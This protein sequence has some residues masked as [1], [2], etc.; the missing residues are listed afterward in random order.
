MSHLFSIPSQRLVL[1]STTS[2]VICAQCRRSFTANPVFRSG[3]NR[4]SKIRHEKG[5]ADAKKT[6]QRTAF[7]KNLTLYSKLYGPDPNLNTQLASVITAAKKA[8]MPKANID[9]AIARGQGKS[10]TGAGLESVTLEVMMPPSVAI[11][12]DAETESKSRTL[13]ELKL[14]VKKC[15]GTVTPTTFMFTRLGRSILRGTG[16]EF[17]DVLMQALEAGAE[18]VEQDENGD[19]I[20]LTQP[21][22]THQAAQNLSKALSTEILN[23]EILWAPT[24]D[25]IKLDDAQEV[26]AIGNFFAALQDNPEVQGVYANIERGSVSEEVWKTIEDN[27]DT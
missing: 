27:L 2:T 22:S 23:S 12:I 4:W 16:D 18:D 20:L 24:G 3:H 19:I 21:N 11:V 9:A 5:A 13:Q 1:R 6:A 8:G 14:L 17:D 25:K 15:K 10:S 26:A 7:S